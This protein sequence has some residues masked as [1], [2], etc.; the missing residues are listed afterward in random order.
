MYLLIVN[1]RKNLIFTVLIIRKV[2]SLRKQTVNKQ[3]L[4]KIQEIC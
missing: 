3:N 4:L 1:M 2:I